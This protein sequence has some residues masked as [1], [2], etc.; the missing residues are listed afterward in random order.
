M[1]EERSVKGYHRWVVANSEQVK[2]VISGITIGPVQKFLKRRAR[3]KMLLST[4]EAHLSEAIHSLGL[5]LAELGTAER[6]DQLREVVQRFQVLR[7]E[8]AEAYKHYLRG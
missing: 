6:V 1:L 2:R 8:A 4:A 7:A 3:R 5:D